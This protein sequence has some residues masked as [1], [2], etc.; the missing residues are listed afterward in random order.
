MK[1]NATHTVFALEGRSWRRSVYEPYKKNRDVEKIAKTEDELEEDEIFYSG[2]NSFIDFLSNR[3]N[4]TILQ[5]EICEADDLIARFIQLHP[6]DNHVIVSC[7]TDFIQLV[8][9]NVVL[10]DGMKDILIKHD[11]VYNDK[12]KPLHFS[13]KSNG[14]LKT[15][16]P[17][18][19]K[20]EVNY[21][22]DWIEWSLFLKI[23]RGDPGDNVF[24]A[25]PRANLKKI[26]KAFD[27]RHNKGYEWNNFMLT[28]WIDHHDEDIRVK[29]AMD[30]NRELIDLSAQPDE[31]KEFMDATIV[32]ALS[33]PKNNKQIGLQLIK[34]AGKYQLDKVVATPAQFT[35]FLSGKYS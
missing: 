4:C 19:P 5:N 8:A 15:G 11:G 17:I 27:D 13:I 26:R 29:D 31:I 24:S 14:K 21:D 10:Y 32:E 2:V 23:V 12:D 7:D 28:R 34:F 25:Y 1:Y 6:E 20:D 18:K 16:D 3:T 22:P 35:E 30:R 9:P 33:E